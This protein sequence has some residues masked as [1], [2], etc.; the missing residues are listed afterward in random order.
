MSRFSKGNGVGSRRL[1][2]ATV[3]VGALTT[4]VS[5]ALAQKVTRPR[6]GG[7]GDW[8]LIGTLTANLVADHDSITVRRPKAF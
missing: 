8:R 4:L 7:A 3:A 2:I 5:P 1:W 6:A